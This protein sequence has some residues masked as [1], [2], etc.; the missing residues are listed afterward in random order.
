MS[1]IFYSANIGFLALTITDN[2]KTA[3]IISALFAIGSIVVGL[4]HVWRHRVHVSTDAEQAVNNVF[5]LPL[6]SVSHTA[7][8][9]LALSGSLLPE[10]N[11]CFWKSETSRI[12]P[13]SSTDPVVVVPRYVDILSHNLRFL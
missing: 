2:G 6:S 10:C 1:T 13:Q 9:L 5:P 3:S 8:A 12:L 4:H 7:L 11:W